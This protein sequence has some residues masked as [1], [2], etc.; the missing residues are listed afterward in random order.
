MKIEKRALRYLHFFA[1]P[2]KSKLIWK[3]LDMHKSKQGNTT[4]LGISFSME[5]E[6][7]CSGGIR[8]HDILL[9]RQ[10]IYPLMRHMYAH[11]YSYFTCTHTCMYAH[12]P[13]HPPPPPPHTHIHTPTPTPTPILP[14][15]LSLTL[16]YLYFP[17]LLLLLLLPL[18][19]LYLRGEAAEEG[20]VERECI[21]QPGE[22]RE[23]G[24]G[25]G[26]TGGGKRSE[27]E[28]GEGL[29]HR[30]ERVCYLR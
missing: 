12:T 4:N 3:L 28:E 19:L 29:L 10:M 9:A 21:P 6:K 25:G 16:S 1:L 15:S 2:F 27:V 7:N 13:P 8:T 11:M 20:G 23:G 14:L 18:L 26:T 5:N 17:L 22:G 30:G 24:E